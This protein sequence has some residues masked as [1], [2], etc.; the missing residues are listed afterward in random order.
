MSPF[1]KSFIYAFNGLKIALSERNMR[2]HIVCAL[3]A[4][5]LG[6]VLH[7][8]MMEWIIVLICIGLVIALEM[9]N[10]AI[11]YLVDLVSPEFN[12][13]A[14]K[15]KDIAAGAVLVI[16]FFVLIVGGLIFCKHLLILLKS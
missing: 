4:I 5:I 13:K 10:T 8:S 3:T 14:G 9:I 15:I 12:E 1:F 7:I 6:F 11:E 2:V 16:S